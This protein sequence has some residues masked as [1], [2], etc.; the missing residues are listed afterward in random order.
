MVNPQ[1]TVRPSG[2]PGIHLPRSVCCI[3]GVLQVWSILVAFGC[4][5]R[6]LGDRCPGAFQA[7]F[8]TPAS[9]IIPKCVAEAPRSCSL[10]SKRSNTGETANIGS[11]GTSGKLWKAERKRTFEGARLFNQAALPKPTPFSRVR[12][13]CERWAV[14]TT[15][16]PPTVLVRQLVAMK[17]WCTVVVGDKKAPSHVDYLHGLPSANASGHFVYLTAED[18]DRLGYSILGKLRWN[19]FGRKNVGFL[20]AMVHGAEVIYDTDDDNELLDTTGLTDWEAVLR[21]VVVPGAVEKSFPLFRTCHTYMNPYPMFRS[22]QQDTL[23]PQFLWPRGF[24]LDFMRDCGTMKEVTSASA[25]NVPTSSIGVLQSLANHD[26]DVDA[27]YR[28]RHYLPVDFP[29]SH[30]PADWAKATTVVPPQTM[31]PFNAQAT[32]WTRKA[33]WGLLL[34]ITVHGRVS[35]IW[36]SYIVQR[37]MWDVGLRIA[38]AEPWVQQI[39]NA[40][41]YLADFQSEMPLYLT[42]SGLVR[43]LIAWRPGRAISGGEAL[44]AAAEELFIALYEVGVIELQDV[45]L[46]QAWLSD[47]VAAGWRL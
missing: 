29:R 8:Q 40:H 35:D 30:G 38:F 25:M 45:E 1:V 6:S 11:E 33:F 27:I 12:E 7:I 22:R 31:T 19:H 20:Y 9:S 44:L 3:L 41:T 4:E 32:L 28:L 5:F 24:P 37:L 43:F 26:P 21:P 34:P 47:L 17:N 15:I 14:I 36:R 42:A 23:T 16:F 39:R 10:E 46:Q 18:Q 13:P 2:S